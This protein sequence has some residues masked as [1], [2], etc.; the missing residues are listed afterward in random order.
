AIPLFGGGRGVTMGSY[1]IGERGIKADPTNELFQHEYGH[2]LQSQA[3]GWTFMP[4]FGIPS[5]I[6]AAK[7]DG[8][9][10]NRAF[11]QD[12]NARAL[13]YFVD[14]YGE[15]FA[16]E[17]WDHVIHPIIGYSYLDSFY[18]D[19]NK[20]AINNAKI[21]FHGL[22]LISWNPAFWGTGL[23]YNNQY[24]KNLKK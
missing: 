4:K 16:K 18:S 8:N 17:I 21:K 19:I 11:E 13:S 24:E 15:T 14:E 22:D 20:N 23:L 10:N 2:Y 3:Y 1:I 7:K 9:H 5:A 12:A 6:S